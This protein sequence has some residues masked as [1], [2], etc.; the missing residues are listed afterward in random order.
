MDAE[1]KR[2]LIGIKLQVLIS[3][4]GRR[5]SEDNLEQLKR[6]YCEAMVSFGPTAIV[7]AFKHAEQE[8]ERFPTPKQMRIFCS[9]HGSIERRSDPSCE[10]CQGTGWRLFDRPDGLGQA[11]TACDCWKQL[12]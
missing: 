11:A 2:S 9:E 5:I 12:S 4:F 6:V 7:A 8:C 1:A 10:K 3:V